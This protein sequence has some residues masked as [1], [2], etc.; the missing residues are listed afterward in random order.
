MIA[1]TLALELK[2]ML[3]KKLDQIA[4][5]IRHAQEAATSGSLA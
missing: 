5:V 4:V 2:A 1:A 3:A